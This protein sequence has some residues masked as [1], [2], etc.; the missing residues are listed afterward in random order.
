M[1]VRNT[2]IL[3]GALG[4]VTAPICRSGKPAPSD[5]PPIILFSIDT[6]RADHLGCYGYSR[7][8]SPFI[9]EFAREAVL[10]ANA[11]SQAPITAP[12]HMSIF[13]ALA[14]PV[15]GVNN[16]SPEGV[17]H[18][19][20]EKITT[21]PQILRANGYITAGLHGRG[22]IAG[23][24]GFARG[25]DEYSP[26][27]N[28][29]EN[30]GALP[31]R[32]GT[33]TGRIR[34]WIQE[35]R[36]NE[37]PLFLFLHHYLC[38]DPYVKGPREF[39]ARFLQGEAQ[40]RA[41]GGVPDADEFW[42]NV[43]LNDPRQRELIVSLYDGGVYYSDYVFKQVIDTLKT[44]NL[45]DDS[46]IVLLSD[47][48]EEFNEHGGKTHGRL[49]IEHVHV[50][51]I[52]KFPKGRFAGSVVADP[53]RTMDVMPTVLDLLRIPVAEAIQGTSFLPL[54]TKR[55][56]YSPLIVTYKTKS[57]HEVIENYSVRIFKDG[58]VFIDHDVA[59]DDLLT[60][61][62]LQAEEVSPKPTPET[63]EGRPFDELARGD[64]CFETD[65]F[66]K[67]AQMYE[68]AL[69]VSPGDTGIYVQLAACCRE[70][71]RADEAEK[72]LAQASEIAP[73]D[74]RIYLEWGRS[75]IESDDFKKANNMLGKAQA[76]KPDDPRAYF[77]SG[78]VHEF[79]GDYPKAEQAYRKA[80]EKNPGHIDYDLTLAR[81][82][83]HREDY[84]LA[85]A[86][87]RNILERY[88]RQ[89]GRIFKELTEMCR[90]SG[91]LEAALRTARGFVRDNPDQGWLCRALGVYYEKHGRRD[92]AE[93]L[94]KEFIGHSRN[95]PSGYL[96]LGNL[97]AAQRRYDRA[98]AIY[99][100]AESL[101]RDNPG[102]LLAQGRLQA[103][104][105]KPTKAERSFMQILD[106]DG[107]NVRAYI[108]L[109][110]LYHRAGDLKRSA[111]YRDKAIALQPSLRLRFEGASLFDVGSD[112]E[113]QHNLFVRDDLIRSLRAV[114]DDVRR[115]TE[116]FRAGIGEET[117]GDF[118]PDETLLQQLKALGY[119][120]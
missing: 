100:R 80:L 89:S 66:E 108:E 11:Y 36:N 25:F 7:K 117:P 107:N 75:S 4:A 58:Y 52:V 106:A 98:A 47:H 62:P 13:T 8:T 68:K 50:P 35:S 74:Y 81:L 41:P 97:Y 101:D 83:K 110:R 42:K 9:D 56:N 79:Q 85:V 3:F 94:Y 86:E 105:G 30:S 120:N 53:I 90:D 113:E 72:L 64:R 54:L 40:S 111:A 115:E 57:H 71:G 69:A 6:L 65:D 63:D 88:P 43:D 70:M 116:R 96:L 49:W 82:Y 103:K 73:D 102:I 112:P 48:G 119:L 28:A 22:Q 84:D 17:K 99:R 21:M 95:S 31:E 26:A 91:R 76:L 37:R 51:L 38:H 77:E 14:P 10:F 93:E 55:G 45:Y 78:R 20:N 27:F 118:V 46:L 114:G 16:I 109:A 104:S 32:L 34:E 39:R 24:M 18:V 60:D 5:R 59:L 23:E 29:W 1:N 12:A 33:I 92:L 19:L 2:L 87:Y 67:A 61:A 15:H 44:N